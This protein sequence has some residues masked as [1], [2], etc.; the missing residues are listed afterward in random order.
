MEF[1]LHREMRH[2]V[3]VGV[4]RVFS[5]NFWGRLMLGTLV[6]SLFGCGFQIRSWD[7]TEMFSEVSVISDDSVQFS[8]VLERELQ[9][10]GL[11]ILDSREKG[12][13]ILMLSEE[14][15]SQR[16]YSYSTEGRMLEYELMLKVNLRVLGA[17][18]EV[19]LD[20]D[21]STRRIGSIDQDSL[22]GSSEQRSLIVQQMHVDMTQSIMQS[23]GVLVQSEHAEEL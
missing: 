11:L 4:S 21:I 1:G 2:K 9:N 14:Q 3:I 5:S 13:P 7:Y 18:H 6:I 17:D 22:I 8:S 16:T 19:I 10:A 12:V 15:Q 20:R 23:L